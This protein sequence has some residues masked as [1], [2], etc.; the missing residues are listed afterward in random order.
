M[1]RLVTVVLTIGSLTAFLTLACLASGHGERVVSTQATTHSVFD[2]FS[3]RSSDLTLVTQINCTDPYISLNIQTN[4]GGYTQL[5]FSAL[6]HGA[7]SK[8]SLSCGVHLTSQPDDVISAVL[9]EHGPCDGGVFVL[10]W[11][12]TVHRRWDVCSVWH[13]PGPDW[14]TATDTVKVGVELHDVTGTFDFIVGVRAVEKPGKGDLK[15]RYVSATEGKYLSGVGGGG[16][17]GWG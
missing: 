6:D 8:T 3:E 2:S 13:A 4:E 11:D 1:F 10:L 16:G 9:L 17:W 12:D 5:T 15:L 14:T 7:A